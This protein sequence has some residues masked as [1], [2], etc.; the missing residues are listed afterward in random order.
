[1]WIWIWNIIYYILITGVSHGLGLEITKQE[2]EKNNF[3][4]VK[5]LDVIYSNAGILNKNHKVNFKNV[6]FDKSVYKVVNVN[7]F[8]FLRVMQKIYDLINNKTTIIAISSGAGSIELAYKNNYNIDNINI[9]YYISKAGLN[10]AACLLKHELDKI[11]AKILLIDPGRIKTDMGGK[12]AVIEVKDSAKNIISFAH[13][14][15]KTKHFF[16]NF[17]GN[18]IEL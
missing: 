1:M 5:I 9:P 13:N 11:G 7:T 14:E 17:E 10:I 8:G 16:L 15:R 12:N 3:V 18:K 2:L 4:L 6:L